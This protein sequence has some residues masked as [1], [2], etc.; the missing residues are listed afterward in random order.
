M[1]DFSSSMLIN[2]VLKHTVTERIP[3]STIKTHQYAPMAVNQAEKA[4]YRCK[5][6]QNRDFN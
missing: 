5:T 6:P 1:G 3:T 2:T 4:G